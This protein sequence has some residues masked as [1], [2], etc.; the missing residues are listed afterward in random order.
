ME[1][2]KIFTMIEESQRLPVLPE[3]A[4]QILNILKNP[5]GADIDLLIE[6]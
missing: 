4:S 2:H 5:I 6:K 3:D 1:K